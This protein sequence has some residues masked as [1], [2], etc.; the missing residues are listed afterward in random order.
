MPTIYIH[1]RKRQQIESLVVL[2]EQEIHY[3]TSLIRQGEVITVI[4]FGSGSGH[5]GLLLAL[6]LVYTSYSMRMYM[7][8]LTMSILHLLIS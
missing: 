1:V 3:K 6:R 2:V 7:F 5:L 8:R 4:E